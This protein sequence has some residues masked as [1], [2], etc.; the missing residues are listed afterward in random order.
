MF[1][2]FGIEQRVIALIASGN[3]MCKGIVDMARKTSTNAFSVSLWWWPD[4][5]YK[6]RKLTVHE[7][8]DFRFTLLHLPKRFDV[9][10]LSSSI[11]SIK[12]EHTSYKYMI[13]SKHVLII[14]FFKRVGAIELKLNYILV[15]FNLSNIL[16]SILS[17]IRY[18]YSH[19]D[20]LKAQLN[21]VMFNTF[22]D[23]N[24]GN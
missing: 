10:N 2:N 3:K 22:D 14:L 21:V 7:E 16:Y 15:M 1:W 20:I 24:D 6:K 5:H 12:N 9:F 4:T 8:L 18:F 11:G 17:G 23:F 13:F 19:K